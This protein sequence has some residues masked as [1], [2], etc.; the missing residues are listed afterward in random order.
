M[1]FLIDADLPRS[2]CSALR[3]LG[4]RADDVRDL[5]LGAATDDAI[6]QFA[7]TNRYALISGDKGFTNSLRF[8][9]GTHHG[10]IVA[11]FSTHTPASAKVRLLIR[12]IPMLL[13]ADV[14]GNLLI[15]EPKVIRVRRPKAK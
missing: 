14:D 13:E 1:R 3:E 9:L 10:I 15:V 6:L 5:G 12:W 4:Y 8:P 2:T 11:R 7:T